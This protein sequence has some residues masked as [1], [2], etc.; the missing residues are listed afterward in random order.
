MSGQRPSDEDVL[1]RAEQAI[2]DDIER[3]QLLEALW[4]RLQVPDPQVSQ[5]LFKHGE[6]VLKR[7]AE[8]EL[9]DQVKRLRGADDRLLTG[10]G[11]PNRP[12]LLRGIVV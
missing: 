3:D 2:R 5:T 4:A 11:Q 6:P 1:A 12:L 8:Q 7:Q 10:G 9:L